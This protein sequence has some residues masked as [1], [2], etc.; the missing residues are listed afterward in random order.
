[1]GGWAASGGVSEMGEW[2]EVLLLK[3]VVKHIKVICQVMG[4]HSM[5]GWFPVASDVL[6]AS[7]Q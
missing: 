4:L 2:C 1:M 7:P 3:P 6:Q 5:A